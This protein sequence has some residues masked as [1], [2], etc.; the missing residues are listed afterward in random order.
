MYMYIDVCMCCT[1][2]TNNS[3]GEE[4]NDNEDKDAVLNCFNLLTS[5]GAGGGR[6]IGGGNAGGF[7]PWQK[8]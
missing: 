8:S 2:R 1:I 4:D 7:G 3:D 6:K 5:H